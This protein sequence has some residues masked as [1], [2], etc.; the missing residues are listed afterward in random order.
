VTID[1][2]LPHD[3]GER[4]AALLRAAQNCIVR[5]TLEKGP[6]IDVEITPKG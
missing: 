4:S 2:S 5:N 6:V 3:P 1:V